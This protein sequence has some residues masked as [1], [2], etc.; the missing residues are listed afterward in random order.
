VHS[1][2]K[3][4]LTSESKSG[5]DAHPMIDWMTLCVEI[6]GIIIF[7]FWVYVPIQEFRDIYKRM[8]KHPAHPPQ[9]KQS[10]P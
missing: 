7:C 8:T 9:D 5:Y 6:A 10:K 1:N 2:S 4:P 3:P